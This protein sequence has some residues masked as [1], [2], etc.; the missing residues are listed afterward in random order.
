MQAKSECIANCWMVL[1]GTE[2]FYL[3]HTAFGKGCIQ[4]AGYTFQL[5]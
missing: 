5:R 3:K 4:S 1:H 2:L